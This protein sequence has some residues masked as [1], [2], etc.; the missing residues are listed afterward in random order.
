MK[1]FGMAA[2]LLLTVLFFAGPGFTHE[3]TGVHASCKYCNMDRKTF[4]Y[5]RMLIE[6]S[7]RT[8]SGTCSL[9]CTAIE[10]TANMSKVPCKIRVGDFISK[11]LIDA[12]TAYWV[13]GGS[14]RGVMT[15]RAKWAFEKKTD[16]EKFIRKHGGTAAAFHEALRAAYEDL[17]AD[18]KAT[19]DR[20]TER[21]SR[22][23]DPCAQ[24]NR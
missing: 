2:A 1:G 19:I 15:E 18:V 24:H 4:D 6:Y 3:D 7:D 22:G 12:T 20:V 11:K 21:K 8:A 13:V 17:Y 16:S 9:H 10:L 14:K 23:W 5:S